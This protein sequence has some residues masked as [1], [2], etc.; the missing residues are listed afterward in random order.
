M[1]ASGSMSG[2]PKSQS[3][4]RAFARA[5]VLSKKPRREGSLPTK[6]F[7]ATVR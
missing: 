1:R 2:W 5:A 6:M 4:S 3:A 7:S